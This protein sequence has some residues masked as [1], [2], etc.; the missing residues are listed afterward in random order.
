MLAVPVNCEKTGLAGAF[1]EAA[2][3]DAYYNITPVYFDTV[4][5]IKVAR[6][7]E[8]VKMVDI[9]RNSAYF[10]FEKI[11]S[12]SVGGAGDMMFQLMSDKNKN[13]ASWL[14]KNENAII[15]AINNLITKF[16]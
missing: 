13:A 4:M 3:C 15:A 16:E 1:M 8:T 11:Y 6:D 5:N 14:E 9:I 2:A 10:S 12:A 7:E